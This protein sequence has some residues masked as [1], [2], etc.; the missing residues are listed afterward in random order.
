M[1]KVQKEFSLTYHLSNE[2]ER[3]QWE[4]ENSFPDAT[5]LDRSLCARVFSEYTSSGWPLVF[6][7]YRQFDGYVRAFNLSQKNQAKSKFAALFI[8]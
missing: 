2:N 7:P 1:V 4:Q 6:D 3:Y 8:L 5:I